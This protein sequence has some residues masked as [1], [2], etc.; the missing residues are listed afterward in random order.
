[1]SLRVTTKTTI[2]YLNVLPLNSSLTLEKPL[3]FSQEPRNIFLFL[4]SK[5]P[6][7]AGRKTN[8]RVVLLLHPT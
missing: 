6:C 4:C 8:P 3:P 5:C 2:T 1:M 7:R